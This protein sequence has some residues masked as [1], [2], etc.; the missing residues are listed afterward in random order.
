MVNF[1]IGYITGMIITFL[2]IAFFMG[3]AGGKR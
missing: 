1:V 2:A 3:A